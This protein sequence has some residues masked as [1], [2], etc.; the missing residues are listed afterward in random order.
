MLGFLLTFIAGLMFVVMFGVCCFWLLI[1]HL[2]K[3]LNVRDI[4]MFAVMQLS[5]VAFV[6]LSSPLLSLCVVLFELVVFMIT[7]M[8]I[9]Y[10]TNRSSWLDAMFSARLRQ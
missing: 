8:I 10:A 5:G 3:S 2:S 9:T 4:V 7:G 1:R 6:I